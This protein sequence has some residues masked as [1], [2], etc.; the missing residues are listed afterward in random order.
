MT[1]LELGDKGKGFYICIKDR[2]NIH[3]VSASGNSIM[4]PDNAQAPSPVSVAP[5]SGEPI[6]KMMRRHIEVGAYFDL[7]EGG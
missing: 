3:Y 2:P 6:R 7:V 4:Y 5:S 1:Y